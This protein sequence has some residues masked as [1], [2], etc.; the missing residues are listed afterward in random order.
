MVHADVAMNTSNLSSTSDRT[1]IEFMVNRYFSTA[2]I[3]LLST[4]HFTHPVHQLFLNSR[5][6]VYVKSLHQLNSM[7]SFRYPYRNLVIKNDQ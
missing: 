6:F 4:I 5:F 3:S 1:E 2:T 7:D